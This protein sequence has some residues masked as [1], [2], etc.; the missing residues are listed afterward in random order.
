LTWVLL[1]ELRRRLVPTLPLLLWGLGAGG[2]TLA[3][4]YLL[5]P[6]LSALWPP[7]GD[8]VRALYGTFRVAP[9]QIAPV[10]VVVVMEEMLWRGALQT[11][12]RREVARPVAV[13]L[14]AA[15]YAAAQLGSGSAVLALAA[16]GLGLVWG[17]LAA[18]TRSLVPA[19]VAH[20]CWTPMV[21]GLVPLA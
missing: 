21:L 16:F 12:L 11:A 14:A 8:E 19:M 20:A 3:A 15:L 7:L 10:M 13:A 18:W 9:W 2:V 6:P 1:P 5:Y 17:A 4:T